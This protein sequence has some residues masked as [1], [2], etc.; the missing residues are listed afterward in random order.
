MTVRRGLTQ[1]FQ[2][3][4]TACKTQQNNKK[5]TRRTGESLL[6]KN[7]SRTLKS[8]YGSTGEKKIVAISPPHERVVAASTERRGLK[9]SNQIERDPVSG[10]LRKPK[11]RRDVTGAPNKDA[12]QE[13]RTKTVAP[14]LAPAERPK[15]ERKRWALVSATAS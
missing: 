4:I 10:I 6:L 2:V 11:N 14:S 8:L 15:Q 13:H 3:G 5:K 1:A 9:E 12:A 7:R